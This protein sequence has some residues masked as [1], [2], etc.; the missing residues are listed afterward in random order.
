M[1]GIKSANAQDVLGLLMTQPE[2]AIKKLSGVVKDLIAHV[3]DAPLQQMD[4][5]R[6]CFE[7]INRRDRRYFEAGRKAPEHFEPLPW[8]WIT[9]EEGTHRRQAVRL[10]RDH[11]LYRKRIE[12]L[13]CS[14]LSED[15]VWKALFGKTNSPL[16]QPGDLSDGKLAKADQGILVIYQAEKLPKPC[17]NKLVQWR[18]FYRLE[19]QGFGG[20]REEREAVDVALFFISGQDPEVLVNKEIIDR[21]L[22]AGALHIR[23]PSIRE[24]PE[25]AEFEFRQALERRSDPGSTAGDLESKF[26]VEAVEALM[27]FDWSDNTIG[28]E[29]FIDQ[30][31]VSGRAS[32]LAPEIDAAD[33]RA[34]LAQLYG[35][36]NIPEGEDDEFSEA[37]S[38]KYDADGSIPTEKMSNEE[39]EK[40]WIDE[41]FCD[42]EHGIAQFYKKYKTRLGNIK[43]NSCTIE[44]TRN[45]N[46]VNLW[47]TFEAGR[48]QNP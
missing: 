30:L 10:I 13:D 48:I 20:E 4:Q 28:I 43:L 6:T 22:F 2:E 33:V 15:Q 5:V 23:M 14:V 35:S 39:L 17:Q 29:N 44:S 27:N 11:C 26:S 21:R 42:M 8:V 16:L 47:A 12:L 36:E 24:M 19:R 46:P 9:G 38:D 45:S 41:G 25:T 7:N 34:V 32:P 18:D 40:R 31:L 1:K 3:P 37:S